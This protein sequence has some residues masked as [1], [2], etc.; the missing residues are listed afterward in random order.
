MKLRCH[1]CAK[2]DGWK[3]FGYGWAS[4]VKPNGKKCK[5]GNPAEHIKWTDKE[6]EKR[7]WA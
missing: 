5:C 7:G 6:M 2:K 4:G 3:M 1:K